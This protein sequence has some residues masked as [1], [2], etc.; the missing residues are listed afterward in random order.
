VFIY[1]TPTY[2]SRGKLLY[3]ILQLLPSRESRLSK[4]AK[5]SDNRNPGNQKKIVKNFLLNISKEK[6]W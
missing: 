6:T 4:E 3:T 1:V 2:L 5:D